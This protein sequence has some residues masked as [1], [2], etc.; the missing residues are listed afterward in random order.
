MASLGLSWSEA[1]F[2]YDGSL[3]SVYVVGLPADITVEIYAGNEG[4]NAG[5]YTASAVFSYDSN[6]YEEV[7]IA[8]LTWEI[9]KATYDVS[10]LKWTE[11]L[12]FTFD[13][14][15]KVV[16]VSGVPAGVIV[17]Y[18][19]NT[20][21]NAGTYNAIASF[22]VD[23][24]YNG[25]N[26]MEIEWS[27]AKADAVISAEEEYTFNYNGSPIVIPAT[28]NHSEVAIITNPAEIIEKGEYTVE[29]IAEAT[30]NYNATSVTVKVIVVESDVSILNRL[31]IMIEQG[32]YTQSQAERLA[33]LQKANAAIKDL[34]DLTT[35]AAREVLD[36][37][38]Y[39]VYV[40][41]DYAEQVNATMAQGEETALVVTEVFVYSPSIVA[42]LSDIKKK[43]WFE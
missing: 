28:L 11:N 24:N 23:P 36:K 17:H 10:D 5:S 13:G 42:T 35:P 2:I 33:L 1:D 41:N 20:K 14:E 34:R 9:K 43:K 7:S 4:I 25:I 12:S 37:F 38:G 6:N 27:I 26:P 21:V 18:I 30:G 15:K 29:L 8:P 19:D 32:I 40:Y 16:T 31:T 3:K 22:E 39:L